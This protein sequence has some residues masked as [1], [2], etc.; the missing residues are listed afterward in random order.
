MAQHMGIRETL[1]Q[2]D[3]FAL[4]IGQ[5]DGMMQWHQLNAHFFIAIEVVKGL[6]R[7]PAALK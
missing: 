1:G 6:E 4:S 3:S 7:C 5:E 2:E